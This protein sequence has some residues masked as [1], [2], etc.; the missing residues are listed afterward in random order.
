LLLLSEVS[1]NDCNA[2]SED[3]GISEDVNVFSIVYK[4]LKSVVGVLYCV[5]Q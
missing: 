5:E 2:L 4:V 1:V 3:K